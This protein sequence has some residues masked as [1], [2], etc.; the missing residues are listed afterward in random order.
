MIRIN[1]IPE[2]VPSTSPKTFITETATI[3]AILAAAYHA[4]SLY[5]GKLRTEADAITQ[6]TSQKQAAVQSLKVEGQTIST[7][8]QTISDMKGRSTRIKNLTIGRKQ[9]V[10]ILD[11]LQQQH[12]E[13][14]WLDRI[15]LEAGQM[16]ITG[17]SSEP[18]LISE[19]ATRIRS[20][21]DASKKPDVDIE[22]FIPPFH[23]YLKG[24]TEEKKAEEAQKPDSIVPLVFN[25]IAIKKS[26]LAQVNNND[27]YQF[28]IQTQVSLPGGL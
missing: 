14:L 18:E 23:K 5:A 25:D 1:L 4:P 22:T 28:E 24:Q 13:R 27:V 12:P 7:F 9:P 11:S 19:Y 20:L 26:E 10:Y 17:Y 3:A 21:N 15:S 8:K 2:H 6:E 16:K